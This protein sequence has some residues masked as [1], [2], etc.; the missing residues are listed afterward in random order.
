M[1]KNTN[2]NI[3]GKTLEQVKNELKAAIDK[4][5]LAEDAVT[6]LKAEREVRKLKGNYDEL[7]LRTTYTKCL[8][9]ENPMLDFIK[10]YFYKTAAVTTDKDTGDFKLKEDGKAVMSLWDFVAFCEG[11]S[12]MVVVDLSWKSKA[13]QARTV[14]ANQVREYI[15]NETALSIS[16]FKDAMQAAF[17]AVVMVQGPSGKNGVIAKGKNVR[18]LL[19]ACANMNIKTFETKV[20]GNS[21]RGQFFALLHLATEGKDFT[22]TYGEPD[23]ETSEVAETDEQTTTPAEPETKAE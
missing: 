18:T 15:E 14:L 7:S 8:E 17:D 20:L 6:R 16:A 2:T 11:I 4:H 3:E 21:W 1:A 19:F 13:E 23:A 12:R 22:F 5:N 10:T 9:A